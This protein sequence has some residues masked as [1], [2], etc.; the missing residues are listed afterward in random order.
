MVKQNAQP[1]RHAMRALKAE[2]NYRTALFEHKPA[3][4]EFTQSH[5]MLH[6]NPLILNAR[7]NPKP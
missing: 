5:L 1:L 4:L 3:R 2:T 7:T 6:L